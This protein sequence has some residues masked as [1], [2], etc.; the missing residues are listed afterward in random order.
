MKN[1]RISGNEQ[2][3]TGTPKIIKVCQSTISVKEGPEVLPTKPKYLEMDISMQLSIESEAN[4]LSTNPL[5]NYDEPDWYVFLAFIPWYN[6]PSSQGSTDL[7]GNVL[8]LT[9]EG[10]EWVKEPNNVYSQSITGLKIYEDSNF[11]GPD[12]SDLTAIFRND[13]Y[14]GVQKS[15]LGR[16]DGNIPTFNLYNQIIPILVSHGSPY[17]KKCIYE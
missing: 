11:L 16:R 7:Q 1:E 8:I 17:G 15:G 5:L 9:P 6:D 2:W 12:F 14:L 13:C 10:V 3:L 4:P